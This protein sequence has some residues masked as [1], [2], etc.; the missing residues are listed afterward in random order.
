MKKYKL[1]LVIITSILAFV[2]VV[3]IGLRHIGTQIF[4]TDYIGDRQLIKL[5]SDNIEVFENSA[6]ALSWE[7]N[8]KEMFFIESSFTS[9]FMR[10]TECEYYKL[11]HRVRLEARNAETLTDEVIAEINNSDTWK[12]IKEFDFES[13]AIVKDMVFFVN[14]ETFASSVGILYYEG[15][16]DDLPYLRKLNNITDNWYFY[17]WE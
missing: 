2:F 8:E 14:R 13:V 12:I 1:P 15:N 7:R 6:K 16:P 11:N 5:F 4:D 3:F 10:P 9:T 17:V